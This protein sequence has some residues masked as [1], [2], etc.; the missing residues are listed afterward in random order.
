[1][2]QIRHDFEISIKN[3]VIFIIHNT[4]FYI[5]LKD[6]QFYVNHIFS[7]IY[8]KKGVVFECER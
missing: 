5:I 3:L 8:V 2:Q 4:T 6:I 1:M 7:G